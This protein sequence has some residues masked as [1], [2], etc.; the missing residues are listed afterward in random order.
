MDGQLR[1][2]CGIYR[3]TSQRELIL[4]ELRT[5]ERRFQDIALSSGDL[6][7]EIGSG[8]FGCRDANGKWD[9]S[10]LLPGRDPQ[11]FPGLAVG[12]PEFK[13]LTWKITENGRF[14]G[15]VHISCGVSRYRDGET[16]EDF[17]QR[18]DKALYRSKINGRCRVTSETELETP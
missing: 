5:S 15:P 10:V 4:E 16:L 6:V 11:R 14:I 12:S 3:D 18:A 9:L 2:I 8:Y 13:N 17:L 7:W 1:G